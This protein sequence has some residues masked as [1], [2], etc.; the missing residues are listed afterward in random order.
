MILG[1]SLLVLIRKELVRQVSV[2]LFF[3][4]GIYIN[5]ASCCLCKKLVQKSP[6]LN[7][8]Q[9]PQAPLRIFLSTSQTALPRPSPPLFFLL[10]TS[11]VIFS[12][13]FKF[14]KYEKG[15]TNLSVIF[16]RVLLK[17]GFLS[18]IPLITRAK[19]LTNGG[20]NSQG[21]YLMKICMEYTNYINKTNLP[22]TLYNQWACMLIYY[23]N[24]I[25]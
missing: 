5:L 22:V 12:S 10:S 17:V 2:S 6:S 14:Y 8:H 23:L 13:R 3:S 16:A 1:G 21:S 15:T 19:L 25:I 9:L 7:S 4:I 18:Q 24:K 11:E 20:S